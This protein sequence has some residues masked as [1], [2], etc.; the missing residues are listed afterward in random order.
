MNRKRLSEIGLGLLGVLMFSL[1]IAVI[2]HELR[3]NNHQD[4]LRSLAA[5]SKLRLLSAI[6][7]TVV[8]YWVL[9]G[10]DLLALRYVR[11][12]LP[13]R[14]VLLTAII[15]YAISNSVG[16]AVLTGGAIRYRLYSLWGMGAIDIARIVAFSNLGFWIGLFAIGGAVFW[17]EPIAIPALLHLPFTSVR[18][19]SVLFLTLALAYLI[20]SL[21][22]QRSIKIG[23]W[24]VPHLP[25]NLSLLQILLTSLDW[26]IAGGVL[27]VLLP[28]SDI[29]FPAF[30]GVYLLAQMAGLISHVPGGL[31]VFETI[32]LLLLEAK[33][34]SVDLIGAML[35]YRGI[36]YFLPLGVAIV[37]LSFY[38]VKQH[39][40]PPIR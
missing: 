40:R 24:L 30:F 18:P 29:S 15:S 28:E 35:A 17:L 10:Y 34:P 8:N 7:L 4:I 21:V 23:R 1:S 2:A 38:E 25:I 3:Q 39:V 37:L 6:A 13:Y 27:Y 36:Y 12:S 33:I 9:T 20:T 14:R 31:G 32:V 22:S 19:I 26:A 5:I 16:F 11:R